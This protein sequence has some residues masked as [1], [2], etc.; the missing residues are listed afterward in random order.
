ML[1]FGLSLNFF[2]PEELD[3]D[4][5]YYR[6]RTFQDHD[7]THVITGYGAD[8]AGEMGVI[9]FM[10]GQTY[11]HFGLIRQCARFPGQPARTVPA[12]LRPL[13]ARLWQSTGLPTRRGADRPGAHP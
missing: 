4:F 12:R 1:R 2:P 6:A 13:R 7:I 3:S 5:R 9:G 10:L 8:T 11:R